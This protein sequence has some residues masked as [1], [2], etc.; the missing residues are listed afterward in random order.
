METLLNIEV[1]TSEQN[2]RGLRRL[3]DEVE[4]H[5]RS[6]KALGVAPESY[7]ALLSSVLLNKLPPELR[8]IISRKAPDFTLD[9]DSLLKFVEEELIARERTHNPIQLPSRRS[10]DKSRST[11]TTLFSG[12]QPPISGLT[13]CYYQQPHSSTD[14]S[15][16]P[17]IGARKQILRANGRCFSCLRKGHIGRNCRS[18]RKCPKCSGRH[19]P[20]ICEGCPLEGH[21]PLLIN[22]VSLC[23]QTCR[24]S[25]LIL[26]LQRSP[27]RLHQATFAPKVRRPCCYRS[28]PLVLP[29][30]TLLGHN[31]LSRYEYFS[32]VAARSL[33][34]LSEP[35]ST[36]V[37]TP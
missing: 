12:A 2:L 9:M 21:A 23:P 32:T 26:K 31:V 33:T 18:P 30:M 11:A 25:H 19:H 14:C 15:S 13:C 16:V 6:L 37:A 35:R 24:P 8:L 10:Q 34:S 4:S 7:G 22:R 28:R 29:S 17:S 3:Y 1:V 36:C 27:S 20:S 5:V